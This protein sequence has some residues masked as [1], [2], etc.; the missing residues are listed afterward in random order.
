MALVGSFNQA[1]AVAKEATEA[2]RQEN[3]AKALNLYKQ[4]IT[5]FLHVCKYDKQKSKHIM[6]SIE[7]YTSRAEEIKQFLQDQRQQRLL[8]KE[9]GGGSIGKAK[10][11]QNTTGETKSDSQSPPVNVTVLSQS[12]P[13]DLEREL[14]KI[15]GLDQVKDNLRNFKHQ[16]ELD[17]RR[18]ELGFS[19]S[20][21]SPEH[22]CFMGSPGTGK[23]T[24]A[25][26]AAKIMADVGLLTSGVFVEVQRSDLVEGFIGQTAIK[27]RKV[28]ESARGG[29][30]FVDEA[31]RLVPGGND[32][33]SSKDFGSEAINELMSA[34]NDD[35]SPVMIFAGY[36]NDMKRF[37]GANEG[38]TRRISK[39]FVF[40]DMTV[41]QLAALTLIKV[42]HSPFYFAEGVDQSVLEQIIGQGTTKLQRSKLNGGLCSLLVVGAK[43]SLD[44]RLTLST[45]NQMNIMSYNKEDVVNGVSRLPKPIDELA[46]DGGDVT[47]QVGT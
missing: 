12:E 36:V 47:G 38:L 32:G 15:I 1:V 17:R 6:P 25:R 29:C 13:L 39:T 33:G 44:R 26:L 7:T 3:Y 2:D 20:K 24:I 43:E 4:A 45:A 28:I 42:N 22:M 31:Y 19:I 8:A 10:T 21:T 27:T 18:R 41:A 30:L 35:D 40:E 14:Y 23:T 34:M 16:L 46:N 37:F 9:K 11:Q 5:Y